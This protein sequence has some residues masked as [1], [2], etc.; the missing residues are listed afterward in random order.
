[1]IN[2]IFTL[3]KKIENRSCSQFHPPLFP[4]ESKGFNP[5]PW[6]HWIKIQIFITRVRFL[7][8]LVQ[9]GA[10]CVVLIRYLY[11]KSVLRGPIHS[12]INLLSMEERRCLRVATYFWKTLPKYKLEAQLSKLTSGRKFLVFWATTN[13][14]KWH[15]LRYLTVLL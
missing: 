13:K 5:Y 15:L 6:L 4:G 1:M 8:P 3:Q 10:N 2:I 12:Q 9:W 11:S 14:E 7:H